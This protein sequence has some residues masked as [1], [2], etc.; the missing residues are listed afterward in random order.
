MTT[1]MQLFDLP[2]ENEPHKYKKFLY[3]QITSEPT[4]FECH[5]GVIVKIYSSN[6][7]VIGV[8]WVR[9]FYVKHPCEEKPKEFAKRETVG[10]YLRTH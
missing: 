1:Q 2:E 7:H 6:R 3:K 9:K 4:D 5:S 8:G 10:Q